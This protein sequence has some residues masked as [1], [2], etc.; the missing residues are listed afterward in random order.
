MISKLA[1]IAAISV[2]LCGTAAIAHE[3]ATGVVKERM[4]LM[5]TQKDAMKILGGMAKGEVPFDAA[6]AAAAAHEI[7]TTAAKVPD[8]FPEGTGGHPSEAKPEVWTQ[9]DKFT[10]DA[11]ALTKA[12]TALKVALEGD[13]SEW[14]AKFKGVVDACKT[15]HKTFRA[16]KKD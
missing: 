6:K 15:C 13:A 1:Q 11:E 5:D 16:E 12:A 14:K 7:E 4:D 9:W 10:D 8:L 3:E 2:L